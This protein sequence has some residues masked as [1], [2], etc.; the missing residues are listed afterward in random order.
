MERLCLFGNLQVHLLLLWW[1]AERVY[2]QADVSLTLNITGMQFVQNTVDARLSI[3]MSWS[4]LCQLLTNCRLKVNW[5]VDKV[6]IYCQPSIDQD[7]DMSV[8]LDDDGL[9]IEGRLR[10]LIDTWQW[11]PLVHMICL[12]YTVFE[13]KF[14]YIDHT[15]KA[16]H[17]WSV[18][19]LSRSMLFKKMSVKFV[20][21]PW[22]K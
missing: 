4:T 3:H 11:M 13:N 7:F 8:Y 21:R 6:S 16:D 20:F 17:L 10:V 9:V 19:Y 12:L 5:D 1:E 18:Y 22:K 15:R 14:R 2:F